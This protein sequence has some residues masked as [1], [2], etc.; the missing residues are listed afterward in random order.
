MLDYEKIEVDVAEYEK[1]SH[2]NPIHNKNDISSGQV[3]ILIY[4]DIIIAVGVT[5]DDKILIKKVF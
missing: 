4:N 2:G 1:I 5:D 3:V